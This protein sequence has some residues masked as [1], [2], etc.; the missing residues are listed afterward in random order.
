MHLLALY[1]V[2]RERVAW[3]EAIWHDD[4]HLASSLGLKRDHV[5]AHNPRRHDGVQRL[6]SRRTPGRQQR[7]LLLLL[8][9]LFLWIGER[10]ARQ[11]LEVAESHDALALR[12]SH[13]DQRVELLRAK[14]AVARIAQE[15][16]HQVHVDELR[17]LVRRRLAILLWQV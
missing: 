16:A 15:E 5:T 9:R 3:A 10:E 7:V 2:V 4:R 14:G 13:A 12:I 1:G 6:D 11:R 17:V 8:R